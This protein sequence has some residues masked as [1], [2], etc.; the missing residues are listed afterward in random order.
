MTDRKALVQ[1]LLA[2]K[3]IDDLL[4]A[5]I[6]KTR[7]EL[8]THFTDPGER[9][10]GKLHDQLLGTV[11]LV[12]G[13]ETWIV[14]DEAAFQDWVVQ[15]YGDRALIKSVDPIIRQVVLEA[16]KQAGGVLIDKETGEI[17]LPEG[18]QQRIAAPTLKASTEKHAGWLVWQELDGALT[19]LGIEAPK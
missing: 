14:V 4:V 8:A 7:A 6:R 10:V 2:L 17:G 19:Q 18:V 3:A 15:H 12:N 16:C 9:E 13:A 5:D 1:R 11:S